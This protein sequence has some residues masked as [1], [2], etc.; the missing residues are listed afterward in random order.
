MVIIQ[1]TFQRITIR[2]QNLLRIIPNRSAS[3][4]IKINAFPLQ[5]RT[6]TGHNN[7]AVNGGACRSIHKNSSSSSTTTHLLTSTAR[8]L[9]AAASPSGSVADEAKTD[10]NSVARAVPTRHSRHHIPKVA[11]FDSLEG[12]CNKLLDA[13]PGTLFVYEADDLNLTKIEE[14]ENALTKSY[15]TQQ[16]VEYILRGYNVTFPTSLVQTTN[17]DSITDDDWKQAAT[18]T[19][20]AS[21]YEERLEKMME[22]LERMEREGDVY[23]ELRT[24]FRSQLAR[25]NADNE[26]TAVVNDDD[27]TM[28]STEE[29]EASKMQ[30]LANTYGA[31]PGP[32]TV[33][34][35]LILDAISV[36]IPY[37]SPSTA[38]TWIHKAEIL[39]ERALERHKLDVTAGDMDKVNL[40][41]IPSPITFNAVIRA[42]ANAPYNGKEEQLRDVALEAAFYTYDAMH[43]HLI[44][45]RNTAT[46]RYI[47][48]TVGKYIP[49]SPSKGNIAHSLFV[50]ACVEERVLDETL[51][52]ALLNYVMTDEGGT[53]KADSLGIDFDNWIDN[54][55]K[56]TF[57]ESKNGY[58]FPVKWSSK[59]R[60]K[61]YDRRFA[62]Y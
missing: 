5:A 39:R 29:M 59:K 22:L 44:V 50:K 11:P 28:S 62:A 56:T 41:S 25:R 37:L 23:V 12:M 55:I 42:A 27:L 24:K 20:D 33:M 9:S 46:Y 36:S 53:G 35:D 13:I 32:S 14:Y 47:L 48:E 49:V 3:S 31:P 45:D 1:R 7:A 43:H 10:I 19:T 40:D 34:Y 6:I 26:G 16:T 21:S 51:V 2:H 15:H 60:T 54:H 57:H 8:S 58:G 30:Q 4:L 17:P 61:R 52:D 38:I 18:T